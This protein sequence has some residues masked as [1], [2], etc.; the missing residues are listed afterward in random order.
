M[1][2]TRTRH[3]CS[4]PPC[5]RNC[6]PPPT[7]DVVDSH[8]AIS[9]VLTDE[10]QA[11]QLGTPQQLQLAQQ[12]RLSTHTILLQGIGGGGK[13]GGHKPSACMYACAVLYTQVVWTY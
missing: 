1:P 13:G 8:H 10:G 7:C 5:P 12:T 4:A 6:H 3:M 11:H 2:N 9:Q